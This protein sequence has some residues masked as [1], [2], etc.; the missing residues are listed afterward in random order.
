LGLA[1]LSRFIVTIDFKNEILYLKRGAGFSRRD[2]IDMSGLHLLRI[3][4]KTIVYSVDEGSPADQA[5]VKAKDVIA[6]VDGKTAGEIEMWDIRRLLKSGDGKL[7]RMTVKRGE[8]TF[9]VSFRLK[10]RL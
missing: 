6:K 3:D 7:I 2:E 5:G 4:G 9:E 10:R 8:K 1:F